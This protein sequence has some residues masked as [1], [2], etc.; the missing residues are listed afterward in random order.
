MPVRHLGASSRPGDFAGGANLI[1]EIQ[2]D[3][4]RLPAVLAPEA[5]HGL[6]LNADPAGL[7][8]WGPIHSEA[9]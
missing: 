3:Q 2:H 4:H 9:P 6:D 8:R 7:R 1:E 5:P